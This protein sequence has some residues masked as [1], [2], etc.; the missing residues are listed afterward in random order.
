MKIEFVI[1]LP[2]RTKKNSAR[3]VRMGN[4]TKVLPS[5]AY[6]KYARLAKQYMPT[7]V[8]I[9]EP[10]NVKAVFYTD[11]TRPIDLA[12]LLNGLDDILKDNKVVVDDNTDIIATHDGSYVV[13][14]A[15]VPRTEVTITYKPKGWLK[16]KEAEREN[17][18]L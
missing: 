1:P 16:E 18:L 7:V 13:K 8:T 14:K 12:N 4:F 15:K 2:P 9:D 6:E 11:S 3:V 10:V 5:V 17:L